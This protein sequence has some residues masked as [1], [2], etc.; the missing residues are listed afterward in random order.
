MSFIVEKDWITN[1]GLRAVVIYMQDMG[2]RC[3]YVGVAPDH[4]CYRLDYCEAT[5]AEIEVHGGLT[6]AA[7]KDYPVSG[8]G[9]WWLGY[10]C[11]H[12]WDLPAPD[13]EFGRRFDNGIRTSDSVHRDLPYCVHECEQLARQ[14]MQLPQASPG[15][16]R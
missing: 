5:L 15:D 1:V 2:H 16:S 10:D 9:L 11:A 7:G 6:Y 4:S 3:G 13:S 8:T 12:A 14:L